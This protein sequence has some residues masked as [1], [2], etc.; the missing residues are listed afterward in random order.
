MLL[1]G[2]RHGRFEFELISRPFRVGAKFFVFRNRKKRAN[3]RNGATIEYKISTHLDYDVRQDRLD[4]GD[5]YDRPTAAAKPAGFGP[6]DS[7]V[8]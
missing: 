8:S 5:D 7:A 3:Y 2:L 4:H 6:G 1:C